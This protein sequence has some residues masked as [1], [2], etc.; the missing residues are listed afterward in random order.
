V[1]R[2]ALECSFV[3][4][5]QQ[6]EYL[7]PAQAETQPSLSTGKTKSCVSSVYNPEKNKQNHIIADKNNP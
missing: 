2:V 4:T 3:E 7:T 6:I 5:R 1:A